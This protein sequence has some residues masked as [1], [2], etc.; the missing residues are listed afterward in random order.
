MSIREDIRAFLMSVF[1]APVGLGDEASLLDEGILDAPGL[2]ELIAFV[3][4]HCAVHVDAADV[5]PEN[6]GSIARICA[7]VERRLG[8]LDPSPASGVRS[9]APRDA[10]ACDAALGAPK[11]A[12]R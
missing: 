7:Y 1:Y 9:A 3:E 5:H 11:R 12:S 4:E 10:G 6:F 2:L 8:E